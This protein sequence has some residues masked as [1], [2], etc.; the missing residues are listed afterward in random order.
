V[1]PYLK[2][3]KPVLLNSTFFHQKHCAYHLLNFCD[4][5]EYYARFYGQVPMVLFAYL[6]SPIQLSYFARETA[7]TRIGRAMQSA[8]TNS[9]MT[10]PE[11]GIEPGST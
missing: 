1:L 5:I 10:T 2:L 9:Q 8:S 4:S 3:E 6:P 7:Q 11:P